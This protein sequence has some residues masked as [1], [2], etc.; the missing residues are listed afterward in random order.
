MRTV[1]IEQAMA[2]MDEDVLEQFANLV[3]SLKTAKPTEEKSKVKSSISQ[4]ELKFEEM[5]QRVD[6]EHILD[7]IIYLMSEGY[8]KTEIMKMEED[9]PYLD[10]NTVYE[11]IGFEFKERNFCYRI[12]GQ[13]SLRN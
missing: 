13:K 3:V 1:N 6:D 9:F 8:S 5:V 12:F 2:M 11:I 10:K 7:Y 4:V